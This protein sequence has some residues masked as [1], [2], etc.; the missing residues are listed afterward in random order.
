MVRMVRMVFW[1]IQKNYILILSLTTG[2]KQKSTRL[3]SGTMKI[4]AMRSADRN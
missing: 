4:G 2:T 1:S 3:F